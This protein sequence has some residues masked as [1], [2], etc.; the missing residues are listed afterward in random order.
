MPRVP[1]SVPPAE[2]EARKNLDHA[3]A[4]LNGLSGDME[5]L[6]DA[7]DL[8]GNLPVYGRLKE[9]RGRLN[10]AIELLEGLRHASREA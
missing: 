4:W 10:I 8:T 5:R 7:F 6:H 2:G 9:M 1:R 3:L